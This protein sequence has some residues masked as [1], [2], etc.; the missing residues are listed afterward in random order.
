MVGGCGYRGG[1]CG[2][3]LVG[4]EH[5]AMSAGDSPGAG[6]AL[7]SWPMAEQEQCTELGLAGVEQLAAESV[8]LRGGGG[9][10]DNVWTDV[11]SQHG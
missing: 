9:F 6:G 1:G 11:H 7:E 3:R 5:S 2:A 8:G 10:C 4:L